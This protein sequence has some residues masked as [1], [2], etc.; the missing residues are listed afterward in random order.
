MESFGLKPSKKVGV[1]KT[2]IREAILDGVISNNYEDAYN[3]MLEVGH[4]QGLEVKKNIDKPQ[5]D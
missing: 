1:I 4:K 3:F 2:A 5:A